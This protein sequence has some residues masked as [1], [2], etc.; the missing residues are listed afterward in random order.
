[1]TGMGC[2]SLGFWENICIWIVV[3][4]AVWSLIQLLLP[5][6]TQFLPA[7]IVAIIRI[8]LWL[9]VA[10]IAIKI[11]FSLLECLLGGAGGFHLLSH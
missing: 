8:V 4:M 9:I 3:I 11:I 1:M 10:I 2:F 6:A 5:Y 7:I